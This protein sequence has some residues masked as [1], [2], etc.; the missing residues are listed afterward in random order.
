MKRNIFLTL[1]I[2]LCFTFTLNSESAEDILKKT[3]DSGKLNSVAS[4]S[5]ITVKKDNTTVSVLKIAQ[6]ASKG[7]DGLQR[8]MIEFKAPANIRDT[9]IL[10]KE[11][12]NKTMDQRIF[13][14][15]L[16][17]SQRISAQTSGSEA[18]M[19]TDF[20]YDDISFMQ[21]DTSLDKLSLLKE[22][23]YKGKKCYVIQ[24]TPKD[25]DSAYSKTLMWIEK[26]NYTF[27]KGQF[28][29]KNNKVKKIIE[30]YDYK[31][32]NGI[33]TPYS[34]KISTL[35]TNTSTTI[36]IKKIKY[37][38]IPPYFFTKKYLETG[39]K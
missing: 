26:N 17:K 24:A 8:T 11:R 13:L 39:K 25:K 23:N 22:E 32:V 29:D 38:K 28:Y 35:S 33:M 21:R 6:Y 12:K 36:N 15:K 14:P 1:A 7:K 27:Q 5:E 34:T 2:F 31:K 18:F 4:Y 37:T 19:G 9:R 10:I 16:G 20:S 30:L 3:K